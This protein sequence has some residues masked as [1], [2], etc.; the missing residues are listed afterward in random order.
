MCGIAGFWQGKATAAVDLKSTADTM[1]R[2][3]AHR[4]P[5]S[6]GSWV[7]GTAPI[8]LAHRRLA[9]VDLSPAGH[10]PMVSA[11]EDLVLVFN[12][13]IYNHLALRREL[14][15]SGSTRN[16]RGHSDT[17]TLLAAF[18]T[19]GV[20]QTLQKAVGMFALALWDRRERVLYLARDRMGEK[21]LY[22][23][24]AGGAFAF[25]SELKALRQ[26]PGFD[27][28]IDRD[29]LSLYMQF[30]YVP[31]PHS[32]YRGIYKLLPGTMLAI[33]AK[34]V[35]ARRLQEPEGYWSV[36][37]AA[38]AGLEN[39]IEDEGCAVLAL[40]AALKDAVAGQMMAD[41]PLGAFLS[42]GVDSSTI[43]A[44]MQMQS[45]R[46][47]QTF[48]V[49]FDELSFDES[50][51]AAAVARH[52]GTD[53]HEIRVSAADALAVIPQLPDL[54]D[55]PFAD[56]S[57][58]PTFLVCAAARRNVTVALSG[59]GAD[60]LFGGYNRH[61]WVERLWRRLRRLPQ[62]LRRAFG[63]AVLAVPLQAWDRA[64]RLVPGGV[65]RLGEKAHKV[66]ESL[67]TADGLD[68]LYRSSAGIWPRGSG[69]VLG[70][71]LL[72]TVSEDSA[73]VDGIPEAEQRMMLWD[74]LTYL[75]DDILTKVDRAAM[76]ISL[77]T[78][79]PFLDHR[80]VEL[81]WR[82]PLRMKIRDGQGKW[83]LRQVL[84]K[85]VPRDLIERPKTGFAVPVGEWLR[86]PLRDWAEDLLAAPRLRREGYLDAAPIRARWAE[87][88]GDRRDWTPALW[89]VLMFQ[90][91]LEGQQATCRSSAM[92]G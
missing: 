74:S 75:P 23:G 33:S 78:R 71:R 17:E 5:D 67:K 13:E 21:P 68:D 41:V 62:P 54:Y 55:E 22:Y 59:D 72:P 82:L 47:V 24:W 7:D 42:G 25:A 52:L 60:E 37:N 83:A 31:A 30:G 4:G 6:G 56:S 86:G 61:L 70:A 34:D 15:Q 36:A 63:Q 92:H 29:A 79:V 2:S 91:W 53:H 66:G 20:W 16:W 57:Q 90:C 76:G 12:G 8:A 80:V 3:L 39:P 87:H 9:I 49:G 28:S 50:P 46:P 35:S 81:A 77:E 45:R 73:L 14:E 51:Y 84:Y 64:A 11:D 38:R 26:V 65:S 18:A 10:Q 88:L 32:I 85:Y 89:S 48:T 69:I 58:I 40:E 43:V 44:L 19:W 1:A 27:N